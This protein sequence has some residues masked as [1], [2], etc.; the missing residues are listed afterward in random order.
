MIPDV[1]C[2]THH[3]KIRARETSPPGCTPVRKTIP[4]MFKLEDIQNYGQEQCET[5]G[6]AYDFAAERALGDRKRG[7]QVACGEA[8]RRE[9]ARQALEAQGDYTKVAHE[10][11]VADAQKIADLYGDLAKRAFKPLEGMPSLAPPMA[12]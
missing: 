10:T 8:L 12:H 3:V 2:A 5:G 4:L 6:R 9:V 7:Y 1:Y 11:F